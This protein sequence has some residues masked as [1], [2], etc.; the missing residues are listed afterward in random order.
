MFNRKV[1]LD[2]LM[3][4]LVEIKL[5][6]LEYYT[7]DFRHIC[8]YIF[9]FFSPQNWLF[10]HLFLPLCKYNFH[11][12]LLRKNFLLVVAL[13]LMI[14]LMFLYMSLSDINLCSH[15]V[16]S[17]RLWEYS[18]GYEIC[19]FNCRKLASL[20]IGFLPSS[21][22]IQ[23]PYREQ[24]ERCLLSWPL[25][26]ANTGFRNPTQHFQE[27]LHTATLFSGSWTCSYSSG[28]C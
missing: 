13:M 17:S 9:L 10:C 4:V 12:W 22:E 23:R 15:Q 8:L 19:W 7:I 25:H 1:I 14:K 3:A 26:V 2:K 20:K 27:A 24:G 21:I 11:I 6:T 16:N 18:I 5:C 28:K